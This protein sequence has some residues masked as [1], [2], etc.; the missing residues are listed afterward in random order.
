[1][2]TITDIK[3]I[4][5][6]SNPAVMMHNILARAACD[7]TIGQQRLILIAIT[8]LSAYTEPFSE[9]HYV[10]NF[11]VKKMAT[12]R[13]LEELESLGSPITITAD[14]I[15]LRCNVSP[16]NAYLILDEVEKLEGKKI[17]LLASDAPKGEKFSTVWSYMTKRSSLNGSAKIWFSPFVLWFLTGLAADKQYTSFKLNNVLKLK[18]NS[19]IKLYMMLMRFRDTGEFSIPVDDFRF[20]IGADG[21]SY[22]LIQNL[23]AVINRAIKEINDKLNINLTVTYRKRIC[24]LY[25]GKEKKQ[26]GTLIFKFKKESEL[27][28]PEI[29]EASKNETEGKKSKYNKFQKHAMTKKGMKDMA[30]DGADIVEISE[31]ITHDVNRENACFKKS[32]TTPT[33]LAELQKKRDNSK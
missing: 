16:D 11:D 26:I 22:A 15:A 20:S 5:T 8:K 32:P 33:T 25:G 17:N 19:A 24:S 9:E 13:N 21:E 12:I 18:N 4:S 3:N 2:N 28:Q 29:I 14:D 1:M 6:I 30:R 27:L 31:D 23:K 7:L 10:D